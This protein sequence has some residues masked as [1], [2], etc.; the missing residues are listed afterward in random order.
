MRLSIGDR[1]IKRH[2][3]VNQQTLNF[4]TLEL[5]DDLSKKILLFQQCL[6]YSLSTITDVSLDYS[7]VGD[8]FDGRLFVFTLFEI[9]RNKNL[10]FDNDTILIFNSC[11]EFLNG[12]GLAGK[13]FIPYSKSIKKH[14]IDLTNQLMSNNKIR[15][16]AEAEPEIIRNYD[17][18]ISRVSNRLID[19]YLQE[20][21]RS[22]SSNSRLSSY[23]ENGSSSRVA[24][25][26]KF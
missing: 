21:I 26:G 3:R 6:S 7:R 14:L 11:K 10:S 5:D 4:P 23:H 20:T 16:I 12:I 22:I 25:Q 17:N 9:S 8:M 2:I 24:D 1:H 13:I 15:F 18:T 19:T